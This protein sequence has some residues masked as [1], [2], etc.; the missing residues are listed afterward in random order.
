MLAYLA[1]HDERWITRD[2]LVFSVWGDNEPPDA[3]AALSSLLSKVRRVVGPELI[4]GRSSLR[5][6]RDQS[7]TFVDLHFA[8]D[9]LHRAQVHLASDE[10]TLAWQPAHT[11]Y[12]IAGRRFLSGFEAPWVDDLRQAMETLFLNALEC[13]TRA[14][15]AVGETPV[16]EHAA[17]KLVGRA[18]FRESGYSLLMC[19]L[20]KSGNRAEALRVF[21]KLRCLLSDELGAAPGPEVSE[22]HQRLLRA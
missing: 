4:D 11:A 13:E 22:I 19:A 3:D 7:R 14:L 18:P 17:R 9:A 20:E 2:E 6:V 21:D 16:A 5:F 10:P 8:R 12:A 1:A 15:I